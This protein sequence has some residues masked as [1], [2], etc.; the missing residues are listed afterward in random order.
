MIDESYNE[1]VI[2]HFSNPRRC[3][4]MAAPHGTGVVTV[5]GCGDKVWI[6]I[7][8]ENECISDISF[9]A[10]GC[11]SAIACASMLT[12]MA[13]GNHVDEAAQILDEHVVDELGG[14]PEGKAH[15]SAIAARA[16]H[17]AIMDYVVRGIERKAGS[18]AKE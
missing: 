15:C 5:P 4:A 10:Y 2:D 7:A 18:G 1:K 11:P 12:E 3:F 6:Y 17:E 16:L 9:Q 14:L 8:V 13:Q